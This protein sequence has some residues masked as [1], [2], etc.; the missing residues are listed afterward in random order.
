MPVL[1]GDPF[2]VVGH[3]TG[4]HHDVR[5]RRLREVARE[6]GTIQALA[7][8]DAPLRI[9]DR[10]LEDGLCQ[11]DGHCRSIHLG[12]LLVAADGNQLMRAII[13]HRNREESIPS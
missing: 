2:P 12:L 7:R 13:A 9:R 11:V 8:D 5:G 4:F 10:K 1:L 3:A 6:L